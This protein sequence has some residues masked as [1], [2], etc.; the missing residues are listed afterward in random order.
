MNMSLSIPHM[1][2][3]VRKPSSFSFA[4]KGDSCTAPQSHCLGSNA[5]VTLFLHGRAP[6]LVSITSL[7]AKWRRRHG[8]TS[9]FWSSEV[10]PSQTCHEVA[11]VVWMTTTTTASS[12]KPIEM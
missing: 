7:Q 4:R 3:S 12:P 11:N 8:Q 2:K 9:G 1:V 10:S 5:F 6:L